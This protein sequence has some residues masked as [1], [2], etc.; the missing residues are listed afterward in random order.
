VQDRSGASF[1]RRAFLG[2]IAAPTVLPLVRGIARAASP[3]GGAC[4]LTPE[5]EEGPFY[6]PAEHVRR[7]IAEGKPG[8]PLTVRLRLL[9]GSFCAPIAG[10]AIDIW[11]C[12]ALGTY[13]GFAAGAGP[14]GPPPGGGPPF[15]GPPPG[16]GPPPGNGP[17][18][19]GDGSSL[20]PP[21]AKPTNASTYLRGTQITD[22]DGLV[23]FLTI[24]PGFYRGR[25][26]H[27]HLKVHAG[28]ATPAQ[29]ESR[30]VHTGQ[31]FFP[32]SLASALSK[33]DPYARHRIERTTLHDDD[34][35]TNQHGSSAIADV[36][37]STEEPE[38]YV[39]SLTVSI[40]R[41]S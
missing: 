28:H 39:A 11:Q 40:D 8:L 41:R 10:A 31:L 20:G 38:A 15:A 16:G 30:I 7:A 1:Q 32:E 23:E 34:V 29:I 18:P 21:P 26:N 33:R 19:G 35:F 9:D 27:I 37:R 13:S 5:Q 36:V 24:F 25:V 12:D 4:A 2:A 6:L 22:R 14:P 3:A 17:P